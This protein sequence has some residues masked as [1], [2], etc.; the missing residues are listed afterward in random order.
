MIIKKYKDLDL[1]LRY[2]KLDNGLE[3]FLIPYPNRKNYSISY[4]T[5][6][7][8]DISEFISIDS[9]K[10]TKVPKGVAHFLEHKMF[11]QE[12]GVDPFAF[13]SK[14]GCDANAFTNYKVTAYTA[15]GTKNIEENLDFLLDYV[16]SPYFTDQNVE[17]EKGIIIEELNMYKDQPESKLYDE[18]NKAVF[19]KNPMRYDIGGTPN[20]VRKITKEILYNCYNTFY[21]PS[22]MIL[23]VSG[24]FDCEKVERVIKNNKKLNSKVNNKTIKVFR[25]KEPILVNKKEK[26]IR[27]QNLVIPK[28]ILSIKSPV[29][30][31]TGIEK[32]KYVLSMSTLLYI[33]FGMSS[34]FREYIDNKEL[35]SLFYT[36]SSIV[37]NVS[38][39]DF[40]AETK[41][42]N[43]FK[44]L[45][46]DYL[47]NKKITKEDIERVKKVKIS[48]EVKDTDIP[49]KIE[50]NVRKDIINYGEVIYNK[51]DIIKKIRLEDIEKIRNDLV[52][53]NYSFVVGYPK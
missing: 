32:Y 37:D 48:L 29:K 2:E 41:Y 20:S 19:V 43:D 8:A 45:V 3:V 46:F 10:R 22:N 12:D 47:K 24:K 34:S 39:V 31:M 40:S 1:E 53:D 26:E 25:E 18:S 33:L 16:N 6:Y 42:P 52:L 5:K 49:E 30:E 7:G 38:I 50:Y 28:A 14:S 35:C 36:G 13:F 15:Q 51:L 27:I 44:N 21:Q 11:E 4:V 9:N 23:I 17:K